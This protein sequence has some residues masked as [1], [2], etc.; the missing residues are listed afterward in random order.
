MLVGLQEYTDSQKSEDIFIVLHQMGNH[1][2]AYYKR[3]PES[4]KKFTP[5]CE[6][7][8]FE[9]CKKEETGNAY[10]NAIIYTDYFL[11]KVIVMLKRNP[12]FETAMFYISDHG[13]SLGENNLYLHGLPYFMA[14]DTQTHVPAIMWF[15]DGYKINKEILKKT[16]TKTFSQDNIFHTLLGFMEIETSVYDKDMDIIKSA[17]DTAPDGSNKS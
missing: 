14:Q 11:S 6:T 1:G 17:A 5:V 7:N 3:Y 10:D 15:G 8:Q 12:Q 9:E 2:P 13:Q 16:A 4:F